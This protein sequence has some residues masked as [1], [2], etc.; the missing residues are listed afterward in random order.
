MKF[1][2]LVLLTFSLVAPVCAIDKPA[3]ESEVLWKPEVGDFWVYEVVA[4]LPKDTHISIS[5]Q[6]GNKRQA[7]YKETS[8]YRGLD[9]SFYRGLVPTKKNGIDIHAFHV[10]HGDLLDEIQYLSI[11]DDAIDMV[12]AK[13]EG[14]TPKKVIMMGR[15]IPLMRSDWKG[16]ES[17][18]FEIGQP[19]AG[20]KI[21]H[22]KQFRV[23]GWETVETK[24]GTFKAMQVQMM[25]KSGQLEIMTSYWFAPGTG[26]I[27]EVNKSYIAEKLIYTETKVLEQTGKQELE[28]APEKK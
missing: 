18:A 21:N 15:P 16:G 12:G 8:V 19:V 17:F 24:A 20:G 27:K 10:F 1:T 28:K 14:K 4:D 22:K 5:E 23:L 25:S 7:T 13:T 11:H 3:G 2:L 6:F 9:T 26:F